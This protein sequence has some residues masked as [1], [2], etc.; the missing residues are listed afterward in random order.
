M[1]Y[2]LIAG[3]ASGDLHASHLMRALKKHDSDAVFRFMGGDL[4]GAVSANRVM[5][6]SETNY[7]MLDVVFHLRKVL[8]NMSRIRKAIEDWQPDALI[9]VDYAGFNLR[10]APR[11][12]GRG[13]QVFYYISPKVWAWKQRRVKALQRFTDALFVILPFEVDYFRQRGLE[14]EYYGNPLMDS[15]AAFRADFVGSEAWLREKGLSDKPVVALLA[16]SRKK[17]IAA[18][19]PVMAKVAE[20]H[21]DHH[22]VIAAA[23]SIAPSCYEPYLDKG[24]KI[25]Y[26]ETYALL[27]SAVAGLV[28][29][30][31]ATLEA[32]LF[33]LPQVVLYRTMGVAYALAK[34]IIKINF[35]S[36]VNLILNRELVLEVIQHDMFRRTETELGRILHDRKYR[37]QMEEGY[38]EMHALLGRDGVSDRVAGRMVECLNKK[39]L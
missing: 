14:A 24:L 27:E 17:E 6:Y 10:I 30:G 3:E 2:F 38:K 37:R 34:R 13:P 26:G 21:P 15:V 39:K 32:G 36:L 33:N 18:M 19:L 11:I 7:M 35:I 9:L 25:V 20:K 16:G 12:H 5:H 28:T 8:Q 4:M 29:S 1:K 22:F 23:P 31:T